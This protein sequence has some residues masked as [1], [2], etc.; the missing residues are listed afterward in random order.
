MVIRRSNLRACLCL[1]S[2]SRIF[3][4]VAAH[5][6]DWQRERISHVMETREKRRQHQRV[7]AKADE[8]LQSPTRWKVPGTTVEG[9][10]MERTAFDEFAT[11]R[12]CSRLRAAARHGLAMTAAAGLGQLRLINLLLFPKL[13]GALQCRRA[14]R[15]DTY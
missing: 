7:I 9:T 12:E 2:Q 1:C 11:A 14:R 3:T 6:I 4:A 15:R 5:G 8:L 10:T 13:N